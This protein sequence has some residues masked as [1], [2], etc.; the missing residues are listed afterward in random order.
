[1]SFP[2]PLLIL[3][4]AGA[5]AVGAACGAESAIDANDTDAGLPDSDAGTVDTSL[6]SGLEDT[7]GPAIDPDARW[8]LT[9]VLVVEGGAVD[10]TR[11]ALVLQARGPAGSCD[12]PLALLAAVQSAPP[13]DTPAPVG[14]WVLSATVSP[15]VAIGDTDT[16]TSDTDPACDA[17]L[18]STLV[19]GLGPTSLA[20]RPAAD[21]AGLPF[22]K[23]LGLYLGVRTSASYLAGLASPTTPPPEPDP[24]DTDDTDVVAEMM[25]DSDTDAG[26]ASP[27]DGAWSLTML[28]AMAYR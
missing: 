28:F 21:R 20:Q 25:A 22:D 17:I 5:L 4:A 18:P 12:A 3:L 27:L 26:S 19:V 9:G 15:G 11:S 13:A 1:M 16:D 23:S 10:A 8:G 2:R 14:W 7:G 24:G 6:D